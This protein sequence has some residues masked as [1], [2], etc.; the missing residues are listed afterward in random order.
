MFDIN[1]NINIKQLCGKVF[2]KI[3]LPLYVECIN[4]IHSQLP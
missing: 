3:S 2:K 1:I 4:N